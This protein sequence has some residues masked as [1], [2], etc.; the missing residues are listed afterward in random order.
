MAGESCIYPTDKDGVITAVEPTNNKTSDAS[1]VPALMKQFSEDVDVVIADGAYDTKACYETILSKKQ[2]AY[3]HYS[4]ATKRCHLCQQFTRAAKPQY[5]SHPSPR[6]KKMGKR[7][8]LFPTGTSGEYDVSL[9]TYHWRE[10][11]VSVV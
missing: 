8:W 2:G 5:P 1:Q 10:T 7:V 4:A 9:Q 6:K 3:Y 11:S